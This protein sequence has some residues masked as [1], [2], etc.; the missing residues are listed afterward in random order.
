MKAGVV[1]HASDFVEY[2]ELVEGARLATRR[3]W[4]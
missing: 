1:G 4:T 2:P 3:L